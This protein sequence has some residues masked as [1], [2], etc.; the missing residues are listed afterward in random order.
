[1]CDVYSLSRLRLR[2]TREADMPKKK[3]AE[4]PESPTFEQSLERL[5]AI[6]HRLEEGDLGLDEALKQYEEGVGLLRRSHE[7]L[8][9]AERR[10]ELLTGVDAEGNPV[11]R[12]FDD[13][14]TFAPDA[15]R[16]AG[17]SGGRSGQ[18]SGKSGPAGGEGSVRSVGPTLPGENNVD[19]PGGL[20]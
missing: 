13:Q 9:Q 1:M 14:A 16:P 2:P 15:A 8:K 6:V 17:R 11:T 10:I 20:F 12:P 4:S 3:A 18:R 19:A 5:E 7:L